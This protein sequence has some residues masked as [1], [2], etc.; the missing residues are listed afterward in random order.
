MTARQKWLVDNIAYLKAHIAPRTY[1]AT[2]TLGDSLGAS[3]GA[4]DVGSDNPDEG[5]SQ[6]SPRPDT[7]LSATTSSTSR[8]GKRSRTH[9]YDEKMERFMSTPHGSAT[10][11]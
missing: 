7:P 8:R 6:Q 2:S 1:V 11:S 9:S 5:D 4:P 10:S 3:G